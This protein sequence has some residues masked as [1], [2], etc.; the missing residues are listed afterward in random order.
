MGPQRSRLFPAPSAAQ[1]RPRSPSRAQGYRRGTYE[2]FSPLFSENILMPFQKGKSGNPGG[3]PKGYLESANWR[4]N[5]RNGRSADWRRKSTPATRPRRGLPLRRHCSIAV[6]A[7]RRNRFL[8]RWT[9]IITTSKARGA[10][11]TPSLIVWPRISPSAPLT[12]LLCPLRLTRD[13]R[14]GEAGLRLDASLQSSPAGWEWAA[15]AI[16]RFV[17]IAG[18]PRI[19]TRRS[20]CAPVTFSR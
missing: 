12:Q 13:P 10:R 7:S 19:T 5:I 2:I 1:P 8:A 9:R 14:T 11:S 18:G 17:E 3:R 15:I 4:G 20:L 6:G 16:E